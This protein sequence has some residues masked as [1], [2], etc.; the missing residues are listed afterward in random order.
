MKALHIKRKLH[1][2]W[3]A[4]FETFLPFQAAQQALATE[5]PSEEQKAALK[6]VTEQ[7]QSLWEILS[8]CISKVEESLGEQSPQQE[9]AHLLPPEAAQVFFAIL[10]KSRLKRKRLKHSIHWSQAHHHG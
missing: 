1:F 7:L 3:I 5:S 9:L 10:T 4:T 2:C 8:Q 6:A